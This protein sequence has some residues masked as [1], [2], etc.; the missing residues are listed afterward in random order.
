VQEG[1]AVCSAFFIAPKAKIYTV[2][3]MKIF[4]TGFI[5]I[6]GYIAVYA[7]AVYVSKDRV[8][9]ELVQAVEAKDMAT[10]ESRIDFRAVRSFLKK[11]LSKKA[12]AVR[13]GGVAKG[14][15]PAPERIEEIVEYYVQPAMVEL[16]LDLRPQAFPESKASDFIYSVR[17]YN[18][19]TFSITVGYP[20][21]E[22]GVTTLGD[23]MSA[24]TFVFKAHGWR[25][26]VKEMHVPLFMV[27]REI[28]DKQ[29]IEVLVSNMQ[30]GYGLQ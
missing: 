20:R 4:L 1:R 7:G 28:Y 27:P 6:F 3:G 17:Y 30:T 14:I 2:K 22:G 16:L 9:Q 29:D 26:R 13:A 8:A 11:D 25:W 18:P 12:Q 23:K 10:I 24:I 21:P 15:G 5:L 19:L